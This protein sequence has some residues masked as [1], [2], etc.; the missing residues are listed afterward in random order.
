[1]VPVQAVQWMMQQTGRTEVALTSEVDRYCNSPGQ[2]CGYKTGHNEILR[3]RDE[4]KSSLGSKFNL[5]TF[6]DWV[7][8]AGS[9]PLLMLLDGVIDRAVAKAA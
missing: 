1:M 7:L 9:V 8:T 4:V 6:D 2:A 3:L 5:P